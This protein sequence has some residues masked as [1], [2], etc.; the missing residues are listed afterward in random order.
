[1]A[2]QADPYLSAYLRK[3]GIPDPA[4]VSGAGGTEQNYTPA[5]PAPAGSE[6]PGRGTAGGRGWLVRAAYGRRGQDPRTIRN[7][8]EAVRWF[9]A[10]YVLPETEKRRWQDVDRADL[11]RWTVRLLGE[12]STAY[13]DNQFRAVRRFLR[14]LAVEEDRPDP[15]N[16]LRAPAVKVG[17]VPV[18]TSEELS[19]LR[20]A[21]QGRGFADRRDAAVLAVFEAT[22]I[23]LSELAG[24]RYDLFSEL[25]GQRCCSGA[26]PAT[27]ADCHRVRKVQFGRS[28][29]AW[30]QPEHY[31][32][33]TCGAKPVAQLVL[34]AACYVS[35]SR[36]AS[37]CASTVTC[38][39]TQ[40][41]N[42]TWIV[43]RM[44]NSGRCPCARLC[45]AMHN[46][47]MI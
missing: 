13:A 40:T 20:R 35:L 45:T 2:V 22:G 18:F 6:G 7:Y 46:L 41:Y 28:V 11:R 23:R 26:C 31:R 29:T 36:P 47:S 12:Y 27:A 17:L 10:T 43:Q 25:R 8:T 3:P 30:P 4:V 38:D 21:C 24:I 32:K 39:N 37:L 42:S 1:M 14:W 33:R 5:A 15:V 16:G 9:A 44:P 34:A 19:A